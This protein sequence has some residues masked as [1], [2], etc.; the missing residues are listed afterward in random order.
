MRPAER[1]LIRHLPQGF[2]LES[3]RDREIS[4]GFPFYFPS[5]KPLRVLPQHVL[6]FPLRQIKACR[7]RLMIEARK[8]GGFLHESQVFI[9]SEA[10]LS[11]G[12]CLTET[13]DIIIASL[14]FPPVP[15]W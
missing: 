10:P 14:A 7:A 12:L 4:R 2:I 5:Y 6:I 15:E 11:V 1:K 3:E 9:D 8:R 13:P